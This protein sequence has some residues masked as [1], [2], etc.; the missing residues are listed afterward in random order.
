MTQSHYDQLEIRDP[1]QR[2]LAQF[3][4]L[5]DLIRHAIANAPGWAA[6]LAGADPGRVTSRAALAG[7]SANGVKVARTTPRLV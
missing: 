3:N 5:P 2:E 7:N 6:Y 4:L 1:A